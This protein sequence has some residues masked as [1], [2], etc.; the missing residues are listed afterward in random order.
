LALDWWTPIFL[1]QG[2]P[3]DFRVETRD[4]VILDG[5]IE[6]IVTAG[7]ESIR[8]RVPLDWHSDPD[9]VN[10]DYREM[11]RRQEFRLDGVI[12]DAEISIAT[13]HDERVGYFARLT[14]T[15]PDGTNFTVDSLAIGKLLGQAARH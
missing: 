12:N 10:R 15:M 4:M 1:A 2:M 5:H 3:G 8:V 14:F 13:V 7:G 9:T 6:A 11:S